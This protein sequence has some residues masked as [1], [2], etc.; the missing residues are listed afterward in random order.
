MKVVLK[1]KGVD[2]FGRVNVSGHVDKYSQHFPAMDINDIL[3]YYYPPGSKGNKNITIR[4]CQ[5]T[6]IIERY[7]KEEG[8]YYEEGLAKKINPDNGDMNDWLR[9]L[10]KTHPKA[11]KAMSDTINQAIKKYNPELVS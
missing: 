8:F 7:T 1:V 10:H 5:V 6:K 11:A 2:D 3:I 9:E 4:V